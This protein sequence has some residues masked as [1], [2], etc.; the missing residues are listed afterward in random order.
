M[1][2]TRKRA[3]RLAIF[4]ECSGLIPIIRDSTYTEHCKFLE[5]QYM[6]LEPEARR[7]ARAEGRQQIREQRVTSAPIR[8]TRCRRQSVTHQRLARK[9]ARRSTQNIRTR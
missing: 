7:S 4:I 9:S 8:L 2:R 5:E 6:N 3:E 1:N